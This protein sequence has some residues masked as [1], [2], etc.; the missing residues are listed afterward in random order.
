MPYSNIKQHRRLYE[1]IGKYLT[2]PD[3]NEAG[4]LLIERR[5]HPYVF[6]VLDLWTYVSLKFF[7]NSVRRPLASGQR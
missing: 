1:V 5:V 2:K 4:A 7:V 6:R 3:A